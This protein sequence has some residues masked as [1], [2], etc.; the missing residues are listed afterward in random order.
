MKGEERL[1]CTV[2][3]ADGKALKAL[4]QARSFRIKSHEVVGTKGASDADAG[5]ARMH[6]ELRAD[7]GEGDQAAEELFDWAVANGAKLLELKRES[8]SLEEIFVKL[9]TEEAGS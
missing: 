4:E 2:R 7:S 1:S 6:L 9:T 8:L 5:G 3:S